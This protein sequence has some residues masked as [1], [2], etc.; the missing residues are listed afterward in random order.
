M[1]VCIISGREDSELKGV[2]IDNKFTEFIFEPI[3][4]TDPAVFGD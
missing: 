3:M 4:P 2:E 1:G